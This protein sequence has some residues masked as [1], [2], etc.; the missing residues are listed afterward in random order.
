M[1]QMNEKNLDIYGDA[2]IP[3]SR[4][5]DQ[6]ED[7]SETNWR[8][9]YWLATVRPD[10]R[11]HIAGVGALW[12]DGKFYFTSGEGTR[13]SRNLAE[14]PNCV[15]SVALPTLDLIVEGTVS[16]VTDD[17]TLQQVAERYAAQGWPASVGDGALTAEYSAPSAGPPPWNLYVVTPTAAFGVATAEPY[18]AMRWR[19]VN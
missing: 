14:N 6:L 4:A 18:G 7:V 2:P 8:R 3:L 5:L 10:G 1:D 13:K 11:P 19:F 16:K 9:T 12:I 17:A 15:I